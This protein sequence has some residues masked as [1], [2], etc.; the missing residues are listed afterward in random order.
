MRCWKIAGNFFLLLLSLFDSLIFRIRLFT[1]HT[2][3]THGS[4]NLF[5]YS[6]PEDFFLVFVMSSL[7]NLQFL[8]SLFVRNLSCFYCFMKLPGFPM[9][10]LLLFTNFSSWLISFS[11]FFTLTMIIRQ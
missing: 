5:F 10:S 11:F 3:G 2:T 9:H 8:A 1:G 4:L 6:F 7:K